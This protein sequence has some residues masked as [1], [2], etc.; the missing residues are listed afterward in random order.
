MWVISVCSY[1]KNPPEHSSHELAQQSSTKTGNVDKGT[2]RK[3]VWCHYPLKLETIPITC[4]FG[5]GRKGERGLLY[6]LAQ[7]HPA[8]ESAGQTDDFGYKCFKS[9]VLLQDHPP[10]DSLHFWNTR[11]WVGMMERKEKVSWR[12]AITER[13]SGREW[14]KEGGE[15]NKMN[16]RGGVRWREKLTEIDMHIMSGVFYGFPLD[17]TTWCTWKVLGGPVMNFKVNYI[18]QTRNWPSIMD[19]RVCG[20]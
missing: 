2:L 3:K 12:K 17:A 13:E 14:D 16:T 20:C 1:H 6:L 8:A 11:T 19:A 5:K 9:Q 18:H 15:G 4:S 10:E 7:R